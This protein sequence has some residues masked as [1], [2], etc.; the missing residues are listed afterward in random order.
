MLP[1]E[2][3][4]RRMPQEERFWRN[5]LEWRLRGGLQWPAFVLFT[6]LDAVVLWRLPPLAFRDLNVFDGVFMALFGNLVLLGAV[7][8]FLARRMI[9]RRALATPGVAA[10]AGRARG[11]PGP[12]GRRAP[13]RGVRRVRDLGPGQ[14]PGDRLRDQ[15]DPGGRPPADAVRDARSGSAELRRNVEAAN[16]HR[17]E[18]GYFRLCV[19]RDDRRRN[20]CI[21]V[22]TRKDPVSVRRDPS[23]SSNQELFGLDDR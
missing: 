8:P 16:T 5:R 19:P 20:I 3:T 22:D 6:L 12:R 14:P 13:G 18:P 15:R 4:L 10:A 17:I 7:A 23:S 1:S 2:A 21:L 11:A 9:K